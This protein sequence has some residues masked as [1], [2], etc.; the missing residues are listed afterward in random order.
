[1]LMLS[2]LRKERVSHIDF[3][4]YSFDRSV[5]YTTHDKFSFFATS[6]RSDFKRAFYKVFFSKSVALV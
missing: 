6:S 2:V 4:M 5:G 1:M 3:H